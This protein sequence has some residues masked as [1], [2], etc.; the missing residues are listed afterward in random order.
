MSNSSSLW[1]NSL[2]ASQGFLGPGVA[3]FSFFC[4]TPEPLSSWTPFCW[5]FSVGHFL[6]QEAAVGVI[7]RSSQ[8]KIYVLPQLPNFFC[9]FL[10][11]HWDWGSL[12]WLP[13]V[14]EVPALWGRICFL[15][16]ISGQAWHP[17]EQS[18]GLLLSYHILGCCA[19][20]ALDRPR[21]GGWDKYHC[22]WKCFI[23]KDS[24]IWDADLKETF[25][26]RQKQNLHKSCFPLIRILSSV[27]DSVQL[28]TKLRIKVI[29][30]VFSFWIMERPKQV[31]STEAAAAVH[32]FLRLG[33]L[34]RNL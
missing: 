19:H 26:S 7:P 6:E 30:S 34:K 14:T 31:K 25:L 8:T 15:W 24:K 33:F 1:K 20:P 21:R 13:P 10:R 4:W 3:E 16:A 12:S 11:L 27:G 32:Y 23:T 9:I 5:L 22:Q 2:A 28:V 29:S 17:T 18:T